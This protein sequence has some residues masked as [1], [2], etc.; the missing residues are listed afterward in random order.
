MAVGLFSFYPF[1]RQSHKMV[2]HTQAIRRQFADELFECLCVFDHFVWLALKRLS[3]ISVTWSYN[4]IF[5]QFSKEV[6]PNLTCVLIYSLTECVLE[7]YFKELY[8][9]LYIKLCNIGKNVSVREFTFKEVAVFRV[10]ICLNG[11]LRQMYFK[12]IYEIFNI[13]NSSNIDC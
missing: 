3:F 4:S 8:I 13:N 1:K 7:N 10:A 6:L 11:A 12:E 5:I 9:G 2:K